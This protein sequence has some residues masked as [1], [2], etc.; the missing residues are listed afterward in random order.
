MRH[1]HARPRWLRTGGGSEFR[2]F[3]L[4]NFIIRL[5]YVK[6]RIQRVR[7]EWFWRNSQLLLKHDCSPKKK[8]GFRC[9]DLLGSKLLILSLLTK[10]P[11]HWTNTW[12][13]SVSKLLTLFCND[14]NLNLPLFDFFYSSLFGLRE[15]IFRFN[16]QFR[17]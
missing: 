1:D 16:I 12:R 5:D 6:I 11:I 4:S 7:F 17:E 14:T 8:A 10:S 2:S 15:K 9:I 13:P 3:A